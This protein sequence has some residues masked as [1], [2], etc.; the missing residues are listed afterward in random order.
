MGW[1]ALGRWC[2]FWFVVCFLFLFLPVFLLA[3]HRM[4]LRPPPLGHHRPEGPRPAPGR[5]GHCAFPCPC[6]SLSLSLSLSRTNER[7]S[8]PSC[9]LKGRPPRPPFLE[10]APPPPSPP[11]SRFPLVSFCVSVQPGGRQCPHTLSELERSPHLVASSP[12]RSSSLYPPPPPPFPLPRAARRG[13]RGCGWTESPQ[14]RRRKIHSLTPPPPLPPLSTHPHAR[15]PPPPSLLPKPNHVLLPHPC[16]HAGPCRLL[17]GKQALLVAT[18]LAS[19]H[20]Q[21]HPPTHPPM[22]TCTLLGLCRPRWR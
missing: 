9:L 15:Q 21:L 20:P 18:D 12:Y 19:T 11:T 22:C 8:L 10:P 6:P 1:D 4:A 17:R 16:G 2:V 7:P 14:T 5:M 13:T 3:W